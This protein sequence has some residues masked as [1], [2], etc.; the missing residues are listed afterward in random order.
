MALMTINGPSGW[1]VRCVNSG[2]RLVLP[3][4]HLALPEGDLFSRLG[5]SAEADDVLA[6]LL[7]GCDIEELMSVRATS[8]RL[9]ALSCQVITSC[10]WQQL[11]AHREQLQ[12]VAWATGRHEA[13][14]L[15]PHADAVSCL[16]TSGGFFASASWDGSVRVWKDDSACAESTVPHSDKV[17]GLALSHGQLASSSCDG[18]LRA[19]SPRLGVMS[20]PFELVGGMAALAWLAPGK[21]LA[22]G[23]AAG[24]RLCLWDVERESAVLTDGTHS[25]TVAA[26][27]ASNESHPGLAV[28]GSWDGTV[29][30]WVLREARVCSCATMTPCM[31]AGSGLVAQD[32]VR[33]VAFHGH[34]I[35]CGGDGRAVHLWD[36][37]AL[38]S[39]STAVPAGGQVL[40]LAM[41]GNL[42]AAAGAC[43]DC[44][45]LWDQ[46]LHGRLLTRL[47]PSGFSGPCPRAG[48]HSQDSAE[49][50]LKCVAVQSDII[51]AGDNAGRVH[52]WG[53]YG[54]VL[55]VPG[56]QSRVPE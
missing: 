30:L 6:L 19:W 23:A 47:E 14:T 55:S 54:D 13:S 31:P 38:E 26:L 44:V 45:E 12:S 5:N 21:L 29:K 43:H 39:S 27:A 33:A 40:G 17:V 11:P 16:Q 34:R 24:F 36:T 8:R 42:I 4:S 52:R 50:R 28:S 1:P 35:A 25:R 7:E 48:A 41:C 15:P 56:G 22:A 10:G 49:G 9:R 32:A 18:L 20:W 2:A 46:R 53:L 37:R 51:I 3:A